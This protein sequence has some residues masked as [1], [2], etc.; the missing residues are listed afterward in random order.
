MPR[1]QDALATGAPLND[2]LASG[3]KDGSEGA[4][5]DAGQ[6]ASRRRPVSALMRSLPPLS[7]P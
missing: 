6:N 7:Q 1:N 2:L 4:G 3:D 5:H